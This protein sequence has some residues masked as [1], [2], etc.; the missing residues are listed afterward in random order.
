MKGTRK[1]IVVTETNG[2]Y[3]VSADCGSGF[4]LVPTPEGAIRLAF[5][6]EKR[7]KVFL[8]NFGFYPVITHGNN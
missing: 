7:M 3:R 4:S 5:W 8:K 1:K 2:V 6:D